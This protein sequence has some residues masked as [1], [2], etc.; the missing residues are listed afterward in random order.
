MLVIIGVGGLG[1]DLHRFFAGHIAGIGDREGDFEFIGLFVILNDHIRVGKSG[2]AETEAKGISNIAA[3][4]IAACIA[5]THHIVLVTSL[6]IFIAYINT[7]LVDHIGAGMGRDVAAVIAAVGGGYEVLHS[8]GSI[9]VVAVGIHQ[10]TGRVDLAGKNF[11]HGI[12]TGDAHI[13]DPQ[14]CIHSVGVALQEVHL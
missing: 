5:C 14:R 10:R 7:F 2:I 12:H 8:R 4:G 13:A 1:I 3:V 9:I 6:K 11:C